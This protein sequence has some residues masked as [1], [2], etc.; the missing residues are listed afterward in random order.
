MTSSVSLTAGNI[1]VTPYYLGQSSRGRCK[2]AFWNSGGV[3]VVCTDLDGG[4]PEYASF[5]MSFV[6]HTGPVII[7]A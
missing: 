6:S 7:P 4:I 1:I 5:L 2:V 3:R